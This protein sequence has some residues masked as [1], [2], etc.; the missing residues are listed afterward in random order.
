LK[1]PQSPKGEIESLKNEDIQNLETRF[2]GFSNANPPLKRWA[3]KL[4]DMFN[5]TNTANLLNSLNPLNLLNLNF[6]N[7]TNLSNFTNL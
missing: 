7:L 5:S 6:L 3:Y 2:K 1:P 4:K